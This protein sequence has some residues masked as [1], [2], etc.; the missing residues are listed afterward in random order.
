VE[1]VTASSGKVKPVFPAV[2]RE[3]SHRAVPQELDLRGKRADEVEPM[4]DSYLNSASL[5]S[6]SEVRI[7][8]GLGTGTVR[9]IV[10]EL[11][12]SHPLVKS[13]RPGERGEGGD[14]ATVVRL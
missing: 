3:I 6:L 11:L 12:T 10:R 14:G 13:F 4:L 7:I 5:A 2:T 1:K 9:K 8:H